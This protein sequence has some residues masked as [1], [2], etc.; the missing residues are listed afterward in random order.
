MQNA[1]G[2]GRKTGP[3]QRLALAAVAVIVLSFGGAFC[4][5]NGAATPA[6]DPTVVSLT[7]DDSTADQYQARALLSSHGMK[8]VFYVNSGRIGLP[9]YMTQQQLGDIAS[10][11]NEIAGHTVSHAD[12][13]TLPVDEQQRQ[14]CNDRSTLLGMGFQVYDF[15]YPFGDLNATTQGIV[16]GCGYNSGWA[17]GGIGSPGTC[18]GCPYADSI[19]PQSVNAIATPDS[20]KSSTTVADLQGYATRAEA[21]GGGWV[22]LV[23]HHLCSASGCDTLSVDPGVL[24]SFLDW[25]QARGTPVQTVH[26]VVGGALQP[27]VAGPPP[28]FNPGVLQNGSLESPA[29]GATPD[30][31]QLGGAGTTV[32]TGQRTSDAHT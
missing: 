2:V 24:S 9:G 7:F 18:A 31:W 5:Q 22:P 16:Q 27:A 17:L 10:D 11:G 4:V 1:I 20:I 12:L 3:W 19:P 32:A 8:G 26:D 25:L 15:A 30:C 21:N 23:F 29:T 28:P 6:A 14:V 13:P